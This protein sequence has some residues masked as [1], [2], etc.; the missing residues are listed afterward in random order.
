MFQS[1]GIEVFC[2]NLV[3]KWSY[4][5]TFVQSGKLRKNSACLC[6]F[7]R[8]QSLMCHH[9]K[10]KVT[11]LFGLT[12]LL[13]FVESVCS[14]RKQVISPPLQQQQQQSGRRPSRH[15]TMAFLPHIHSHDHCLT[16]TAKNGLWL[17]WYHTHTHT[18]RAFPLYSRCQNTSGWLCNS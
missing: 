3:G 14:A 2:V 17:I 11:F 10:I 16:H 15:E 13:V 8:L 1:H 7:L 9:G 18:H 6:H 12:L 4:F 5:T